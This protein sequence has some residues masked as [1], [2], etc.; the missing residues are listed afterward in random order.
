MGNLKTGFSSNF[1]GFYTPLRL[2]AAVVVD[3]FFAANHIQQMDLRGCEGKNFVPVNWVSEAITTLIDQPACEGV[4]FA[5]VSDDPVPVY[6]LKR[7]WSG[8]ELDFCLKPQL[9]FPC[10]SELVSGKIHSSF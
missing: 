6:R 3:R 5:V 7:I 10:T 1:E 2:S 8:T 9:Y 4:A